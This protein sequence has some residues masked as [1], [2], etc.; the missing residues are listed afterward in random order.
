[1]TPLRDPLD[2]R[3]DVYAV[4]GCTEQCTAQE[5]RRASARRLAEPK[6]DQREVM[7]A[8]DTVTY[9]DQRVRYDVFSYA[10]DLDVSNVAPPEQP[11]GPIGRQIPIETEVYRP[12]SQD[13]VNVLVQTAVEWGRIEA[14]VFE[15]NGANATPSVPVRDIVFDV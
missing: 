3:I 4:L 11:T 8:R 15:F 7:K 1:M 10:I 9:P 14:P 5:A 12:Q 13:L 2:K 6:A